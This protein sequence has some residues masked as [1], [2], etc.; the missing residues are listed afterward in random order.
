VTV[1]VTAILTVAAA[2]KIEPN[3]KLQSELRA[4]ENDFSDLVDHVTRKENRDRVRKMRD[5]REAKSAE[6]EVPQSGTA[7]HKQYLR[8]LARTRGLLR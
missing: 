7:E 5:G 6:P 2:R 8:D 1:W 4:L 3:A